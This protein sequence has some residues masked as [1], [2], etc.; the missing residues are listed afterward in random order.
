MGIEAD[1]SLSA[2][3][4]ALHTQNSGFANLAVTSGGKY[5]YQMTSNGPYGFS[6]DPNTGALTPLPSN[7]PNSCCDFYAI[8][9]VPAR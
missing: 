5:L 2:A 8:T 3:V 7:P 6:I 1:V 4:S 9:T